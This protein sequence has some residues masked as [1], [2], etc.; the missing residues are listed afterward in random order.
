MKQFLMTT[1]SLTL[2]KTESDV[3]LSLNSLLNQSNNELQ[4]FAWCLLKERVKHLICV[5]M[6]CVCC[7]SFEENKR[8]TLPI[9]H[10]RLASHGTYHEIDHSMIQSQKIY[11]AL[12]DDVN[13][14]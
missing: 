14:R 4:S 5:C 8:T 3:K 1:A 11:I 13:L 6:F 10:Q 7:I 2:S 9:Q 12:L